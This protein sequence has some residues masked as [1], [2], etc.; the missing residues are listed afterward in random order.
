MAHQ[1]E[2]EN[3][4]GLGTVIAQEKG[5]IEIRTKP[6]APG[7]G[8]VDQ[9]PFNPDFRIVFSSTGPISTKRMLSNRRIREKINQFGGELIR[10]FMKK[11]SPREFM[12][13]S[14]KFSEQTQLPSENLQTG[15][16]LLDEHGFH[17]SSMALF[18]E[19]IFSLVWVN[20]VED[21][22][23]VLKAWNKQGET[24][25]AEVDSIGA[26]LVECRRDDEDP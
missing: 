11:A 18:G 17:S 13:L 7:I 20:E 19:T 14:R 21:A 10:Q 24:L 3:K 1:A 4:T 16:K 2:V 23:S 6:G 9:V 5:G 22:V 15:L 8:H 26:R 25:S 12:R